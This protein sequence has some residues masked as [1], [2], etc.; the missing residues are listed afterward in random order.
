[1]MYLGINRETGAAITDTEHIR[2][3]VRDILITPE[4]SRAFASAPSTSTS[5]APST[6][7]WWSI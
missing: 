6:A 1:M 3:S 5:P 7:Q 4:G 2:K